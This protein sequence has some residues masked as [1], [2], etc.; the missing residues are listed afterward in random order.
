MK[1]KQKIKWTAQDLKSIAAFHRI[2][3]NYMEMLKIKSEASAINNQ[4]LKT[5][6]VKN[7]PV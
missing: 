3:K 2:I 7:L 4:M 6:S 1:Q 5:Q